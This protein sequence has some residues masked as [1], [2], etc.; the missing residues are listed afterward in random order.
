[1]DKEKKN[2]NQTSGKKAEELAKA[3][4]KQKGF[5]ILEQNYRCRRGE[6]D[7]IG[8]DGPYLVFVEVKARRSKNYGYPAEAVDRRKQ[9]KICQ[10]CDYYCYRQGIFSDCPI[11]FDVIEILRNKIRHIENAFDYCKK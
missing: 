3:Y 2:E 11:R 10:V 5:L 7:L 6:V 9:M 1:M 8:R 4:L